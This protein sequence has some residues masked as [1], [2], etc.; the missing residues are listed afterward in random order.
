[1]VRRDQG[2][3]PLDAARIVRFGRP[4]GRAGF[5]LSRDL[6]DP[7]GVESAERVPR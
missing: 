3:E 7:V 2:G 4:R 5:G 6:G 1:M